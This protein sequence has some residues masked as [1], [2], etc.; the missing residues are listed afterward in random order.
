MSDEL[1]LLLG[2]LLIDVKSDDEVTVWLLRRA[3]E[4]NK[5]WEEVEKNDRTTYTYTLLNAVLNLLQERQAEV[6]PRDEE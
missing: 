6:C 2:E 5:H 3:I 1:E 4:L